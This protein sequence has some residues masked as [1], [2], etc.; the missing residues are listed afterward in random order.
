VDLSKL[1]KGEKIVLAT[2]VLLVL[3]L[4]FLPWHRVELGPVLGVN[5]PSIDIK[6]VEAPNGGY[7]VIAVILSLVMAAQIVAA[8]FTTAKLPTPPVPWPQVHLYAGFAVAG[9]VVLKL[10]VETTALGPGAWLGVLL[11]GGVAY[12]GFT[13]SKEPRTSPGVV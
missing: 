6:A 5:L 12:G 10:L 8:K 11:A 4:L 9:L 7:A 3:D 1:T 2:G 13:I